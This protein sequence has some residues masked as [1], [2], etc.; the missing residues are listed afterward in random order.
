MRRINYME[1]N[2]TI[3][4]YDSFL[5]RTICKLREIDDIPNVGDIIIIGQD[6]EYIVTCRVFRTCP[7]PKE[8]A[9]RNQFSLIKVM[10]IRK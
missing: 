2:V 5:K 10:V 9:F 6:E 7:D 3:E 8:I 4:I 1:K